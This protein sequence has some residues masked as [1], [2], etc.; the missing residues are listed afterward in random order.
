LKKLAQTSK[1]LQ[2]IYASYNILY[3]LKNSITRYCISGKI[4]P[5]IIGMKNLD[6]PQH[7][8][9]SLFPTSN[10]GDVI[11]ERHI[12][13]STKNAARLSKSQLLDIIQKCW[14]LPEFYTSFAAFNG[15]PN[16]LNFRQTNA[17]WCVITLPLNHRDILLDQIS[18]KLS[19]HGIPLP[20]ATVYDGNS[21][22]LVWITNKS[23]LFNDF[24]LWFLCQTKL[25]S[26]LE[27]FG[28]VTEKSDIN[29]T[30]RLIGTTNRQKSVNVRIENN[31][32]RIFEKEELIT[33]VLKNVSADHFR[34][35]ELKFLRF[36]DLMKLVADRWWDIHKYPELYSDW[37]LFLGTSLSDFCP[38]HR[39]EEDTKAL[40]ET[41]YGKSW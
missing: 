23:F 40:S 24:Y 1:N 36:C 17:L 29:N 5:I 18:W 3:E 22:I 12:G 8:F 38:I 27:Q 25:T 10:V 41:I 28:S 16:T 39:I 13:T 19:M 34:S 32:G 2:R 6:S 31:T 7:F 14:G 37:M 26:I 21:L 30:F 20:T 35:A 9:G 4:S 33:K 11:L 15:T